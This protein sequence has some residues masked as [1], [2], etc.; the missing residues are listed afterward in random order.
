M[1][2]LTKAELEANRA[3]VETEL[4]ARGYEIKDIF[5]AVDALE[6]LAIASIKRR[7]VRELL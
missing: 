5:V 2:L 3:A 4:T 1:K 7:L 6:K